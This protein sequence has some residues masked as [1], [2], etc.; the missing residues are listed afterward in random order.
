MALQVV[1]VGLPKS[2]TTTLYKA[3]L[4]AGFNAVH[5]NLPN[6]AGPAGIMLQRAHLRGWQMSAFLNGVEAVAQLDSSSA[7]NKF[8]WPQFDMDF[9]RG[10]LWAG[11]KLVHLVRDPTAT[12][13]SMKHQG[14]P[15]LRDRV[16][17][18]PGLFG[19]KYTTD[20]DIWYWIQRHRRSIEREFSGA[21]HYIQIDINDQDASD[22]LADF[23][24]RPFPVWGHENKRKT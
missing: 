14:N 16:T 2:G 19:P 4:G 15:S 13:D 1:N 24:H 9:I 23:F 21:G 10:M 17:K 11:T 6:K 22:R 5:Q 20:K 7:G 8:A 3:F 12:L 18:A